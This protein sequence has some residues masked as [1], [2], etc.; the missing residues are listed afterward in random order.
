V[1]DRVRDCDS[2][3]W[4]SRPG[5]SGR[6]ATGA[7]SS[8][9]LADLAQPRRFWRLERRGWDSNPRTSIH[10]L[11]VFKIWCWSLRRVPASRG[12]EPGTL[13]EEAGRGSESNGTTFLWEV[14]RLAYPLRLE[15]NGRSERIGLPLVW[16]SV[17]GIEPATA[18]RSSAVWFPIT[19]ICTPSSTMSTKPGWPFV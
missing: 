10:P 17:P 2:S 1:R 13:L 6:S 7:G 3:A 15:F 18:I 14:I 12:S 5:D 11:P 9:E 8:W 19:T 4:L 16:A